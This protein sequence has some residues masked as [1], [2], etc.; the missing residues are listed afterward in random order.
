MGEGIE[1]MISGEDRRCGDLGERTGCAPRRSEAARVELPCPATTA[2]VRSLLLEHDTIYPDG[3]SRWLEDGH[4]YVGD[5]QA[6]A[7]CDPPAVSTL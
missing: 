4:V 6:G 5:V 7:C 1:A 2:Q 3:W